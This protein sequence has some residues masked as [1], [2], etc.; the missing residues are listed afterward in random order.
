MH[1]PTEKF[2]VYQVFS[3]VH[4][5]GWVTVDKETYMASGLEKRRLAV[6]PDYEIVAK[7]WYSLGQGAT[8]HS[9]YL[10]TTSNGR[11]ELLGSA[12]M[13]YGFGDHWQVTAAKLVNKLLPGVFPEFEQASAVASIYLRDECNIAASVTDVKRKKDM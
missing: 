10:Y 8:F 12:E 11:Y 9:V 2:I 6:M 13:V 3:P 7:R 1:T 5:P 4:R